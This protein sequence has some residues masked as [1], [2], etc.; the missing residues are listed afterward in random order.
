M[1]PGDRVCIKTTGAPVTVL[2]KSGN[3]V[4]VRR[5]AGY[6]WTYYTRELGDCPERDEVCQI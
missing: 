1:K 6:Q 2:V 3:N 4:L 5:E